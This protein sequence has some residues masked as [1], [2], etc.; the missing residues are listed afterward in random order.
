MVYY[1][2]SM[3]R[4]HHAWN[5][6][7][8]ADEVELDTHSRRIRPSPS[9]PAAKTDPTKGPPMIPLGA[10]SWF[11]LCGW[12][13]DRIGL[14]VPELILKPIGAILAVLVLAYVGWAIVEE[15][16]GRKRTL[17]ETDGEEGG[18]P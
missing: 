8:K 16:R 13:Y 17:P 10:Y 1:V 18:K 5:V 4:N 11:E 14:T 2:V 15:L 7:F 9:Q 6:V 3:D 12:P